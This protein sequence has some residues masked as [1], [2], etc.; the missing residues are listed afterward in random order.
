MFKLMLSAFALVLLVI[1]AASGVDHYGPDN[2]GS[3]NHGSNNHGPDMSYMGG[4]VEKDMPS[5]N[6]GSQ[7]YDH[8]APQDGYSDQ[9]HKYDKA[10]NYYDWLSPGAAYWYPTSYAYNYRYAYPQ[11]PT[12]TTPVTY[13]YNWNPVVYNWDPW[14]AANVYGFGSTTYYYSS[15][16]WSYHNGGFVF[17]L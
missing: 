3:D 17:G 1:G 7:L 15:S 13:Y 10:Y 5:G 16:S 12:Y 14:W 4:H 8:H 11:Y 6:G 9:T 2:Y